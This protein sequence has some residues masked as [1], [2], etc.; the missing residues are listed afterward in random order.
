M[1]SIQADL[2]DELYERIQ[3]LVKSGWVSSEAELIRNALRRY[4]NAHWPEL[5]DEF[6]RSDVEWGFR[7]DG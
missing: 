4:L 7:G 1:K 5:M 6:I 2:P 3:A